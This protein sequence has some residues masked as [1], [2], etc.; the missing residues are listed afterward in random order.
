MTRG[1]IG[2]Q[3]EQRVVGWS[4]HERVGILSGQVKCRHFA[5]S[6]RTLF[7]NVLGFF[8]KIAAHAFTD[9]IDTKTVDHWIEIGTTPEDGKPDRMFFR[10]VQ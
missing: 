3:Q 7:E 6:Y 10:Y 9:R 2:Q 4:F 5:K 8:L 1:Y